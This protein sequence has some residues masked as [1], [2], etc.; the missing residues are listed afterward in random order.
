MIKSVR[1]EIAM[2]KVS[3]DTARLFVMTLG[4]QPED[5]T[6]AGVPSVRVSGPSCTTKASVESSTV[7]AFV[8]LTT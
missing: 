4:L 1:D 6:P 3:I 8:V 2:L 7:R 5:G